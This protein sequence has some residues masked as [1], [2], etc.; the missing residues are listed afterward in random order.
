M[1]ASIL[2]TTYNHGQ[3]IADALDGALKQ[4]ADFDFE[5]VI[6]EDCSTDGTLAVCQQYQQQHPDKIR[7]ISQP[8]NV[9]LMANFVSTMDACQGEYIAMLS[10]DD[11]WTDAQ[12]LAA[13]VSFLEANPDHAGSST[14]ANVEFHGRTDK[15]LLCKYVPTKESY[16]PS[17]MSTFMPAASSLVFKKDLICPLPQWFLTIEYE[18]TAIRGMLAKHGKFHCLQRKSVTYRCN[19]WG[20]WQQLRKK[21]STYM[22]DAAETIKHHILQPA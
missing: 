19:N 16:Q 17:E 13:Q 1:K 11:F 18:D 21:G 8:K 7:V 4:V 22:A 2:I 20:A 9:G 10:G 15:R 5:I 6:G 12:K 3:W 14:Q